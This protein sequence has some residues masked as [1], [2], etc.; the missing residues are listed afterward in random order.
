MFLGHQ[1]QGL[2]V[3]DWVFFVRLVDCGAAALEIEQNDNGNNG[4]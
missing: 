2:T 3:S 4:D 1:Y